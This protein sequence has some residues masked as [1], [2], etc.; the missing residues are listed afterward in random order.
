[1]QVQIEVITDNAGN[2]ATIES[3]GCYT[4]PAIYEDA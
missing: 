4:D 3:Y 2:G 1:M